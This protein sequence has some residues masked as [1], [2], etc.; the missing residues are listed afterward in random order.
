MSKHKMEDCGTLH[1]KEQQDFL[2]RIQ[3][4]HCTHTHTYTHTVAQTHHTHRSTSPPPAL[5]DLPASCCQSQ[6]KTGFVGFVK[7]TDKTPLETAGLQQHKPQ[8]Y[9]LRRTGNLFPI[10]P[11][12][13]T[14]LCTIEQ[15]L[16]RKL[17]Q[18]IG[19]W[20]R[21]TSW[22]GLPSPHT[23]IIKYHTRFLI[24]FLFSSLRCSHQPRS[25]FL[26]LFLSAPFFPL[27]LNFPPLI[28]PSH[29][30]P[31]VFVECMKQNILM[32]V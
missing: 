24:N 23:R 2:H 13:I 7:P 6:G 14:V 15:Q 4:A 20:R 18:G 19:I 3:Y 26:R 32:D 9:P 29:S 5:E 8:P 1:Y 21:R 25:P 16:S 30:R 17:S 27:F 11:G 22:C 28:C 12:C 31:A 10:L